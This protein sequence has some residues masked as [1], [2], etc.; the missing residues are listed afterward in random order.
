MKSQASHIQ[1]KGRE[2]TTD[3]KHN[4]FKKWVKKMITD[5]K[6]EQSDMLTQ[7]VSSYSLGYD[8][9]Y[10]D[11]M[12][13]DWSATLWC[14]AFIFSLFTLHRFLDFFLCPHLR[15]LQFYTFSGRMN[16]AESF[17]INNDIIFGQ[18]HLV[19]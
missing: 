16:H 9:T 12:N 14:A 6:N 2:G 5:D 8:G 18:E 3:K 11:V 1:C 17:G 7:T 4:I 19:N 13:R 10:R 15:C